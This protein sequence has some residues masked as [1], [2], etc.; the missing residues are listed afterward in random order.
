MAPL[1]LDLTMQGHMGFPDRYIR[2]FPGIHESE[3]RQES[4]ILKAFWKEN[5]LD[6]DNGSD[7]V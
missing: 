3:N 4:D 2:V 1:Y 6:T 5:P 7:H